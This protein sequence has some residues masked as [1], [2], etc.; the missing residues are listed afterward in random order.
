MTEDIL[1]LGF[2]ENITGKRVGI[3]KEKLIEVKFELVS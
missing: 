2:K 3:S 1:I